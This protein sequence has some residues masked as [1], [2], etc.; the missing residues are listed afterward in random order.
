MVLAGDLG[1]QHPWQGVDSGRGD[2]CGRGEGEGR[3]EGCR[4]VGV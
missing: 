1:R 4:G 2:H 3:G